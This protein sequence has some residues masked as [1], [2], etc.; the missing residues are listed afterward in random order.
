MRNG[1]ALFGFGGQNA[2][3][4]LLVGLLFGGLGEPAGELLIANGLSGSQ[5]SQQRADLLRGQ[6][7]HDLVKTLQ[8]TRLR[9][10]T[11]VYYDFSI[12]N[13]HRV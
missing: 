2:G 10:P 9:P 13:E 1:I 6:N 5:K 7:I 3:D 4:C 11:E 8:V 12:S